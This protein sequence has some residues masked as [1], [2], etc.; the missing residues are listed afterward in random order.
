M[1]MGACLSVC[2]TKFQTDF[3]EELKK[4]TAGN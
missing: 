3:N 1:G 2:N 4:I